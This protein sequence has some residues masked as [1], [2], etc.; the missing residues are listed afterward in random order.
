M[1]ASLSLILSPSTAQITYHF[2]SSVATG[3]AVACR[4]SA[5]AA[6]GWVDGRPAGQRA[7][8]VPSGLV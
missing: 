2:L 8:G 3:P 1:T 6:A 5:T 4:S 7:A